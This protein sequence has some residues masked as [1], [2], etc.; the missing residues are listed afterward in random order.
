MGYSP[1]S[2]CSMEHT[3]GGAIMRQA[4]SQA[5]LDRLCECAPVV[6]E[7]IDGILFL[8]H[9]KTYAANIA[10]KLKNYIETGGQVPK[11]FIPAESE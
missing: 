9:G 7:I 5:Q 10:F 3:N 6:M 2:N 8:E 1:R 11:E 4:L